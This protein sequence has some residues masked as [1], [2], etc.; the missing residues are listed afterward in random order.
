[1]VQRLPEF[2][3]RGSTNYYDVRLGRVNR[4]QFLR[5][6]VASNNCSL[7]QVAGERVCC[8]LFTAIPIGDTI[9]VVATH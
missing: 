2:R 5:T 3:C 7:V 6:L 9:N 4:T 8:L 1:M